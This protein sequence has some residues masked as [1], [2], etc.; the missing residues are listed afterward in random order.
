MDDPNVKL[1]FL[2]QLINQLEISSEKSLLDMESSGLHF[3]HGAF[4]NG[5]KNVKWDVSTAL[6][7]FC[8]WFHESS[9]KRADYKKTNY[10]S[11]FPMKFC[12]ARCVENVN[13][14]QSFGYL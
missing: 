7:R 3:V 13:L 5:H 4:Q 8:K 12:T 11:V 6:Q 10:N 9:A 1:K 14:V 2:D